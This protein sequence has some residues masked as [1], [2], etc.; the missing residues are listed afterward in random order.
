MANSTVYHLGGADGETFSTKRR[1][2]WIPL[3]DMS[4]NTTIRRLNARYSSPEIV[5]AKIYADGD[6]SSAVWTSPTGQIE[7]NTGTGK[8]KYKSLAVGRRANSIMVEVSTTSSSS[9]ALEISKLE[10]EVDG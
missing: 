5:T 9:T 1:T 7:A 3:T 10:V 4:R 8:K 2:G 6:D